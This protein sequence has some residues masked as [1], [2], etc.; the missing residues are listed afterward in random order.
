M[1]EDFAVMPVPFLTGSD[2]REMARMQP[3]QLFGQPSGQPA[4]GPADFLTFFSTD[5]YHFSQ[6]GNAH[7]TYHQRA[8]AA[9]ARAAEQKRRISYS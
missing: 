4:S 7:G 1:R 8:R 9:R 5:C 2:L 3:T 6:K